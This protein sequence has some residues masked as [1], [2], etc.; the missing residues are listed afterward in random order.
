ML[1]L[2]LPE[3]FDVSKMLALEPEPDKN[4][5]QECEDS[6]PG[7]AVLRA[8]E[9]GYSEGFGI[10]GCGLTQP[11]WWA[12][13]ARQSWEEQANNNRFPAMSVGPKDVI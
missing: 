12:A 11:H 1:E 8:N 2:E 10:K 5:W 13:Y 9:A 3:R 6:N 4:N 7:P